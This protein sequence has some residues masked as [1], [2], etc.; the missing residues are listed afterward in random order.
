MPA[1]L[2]EIIRAAICDPGSVL[3]RHPD[4]RDGLWQT[5]AVLVALAGAGYVMVPGPV[6]T[7]WG[8]VPPTWD[9]INPGVV[10]DVVGSEARARRIVTYSADQVV[11][12]QATEW[13]PAPAPDGAA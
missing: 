5:R 9:G 10:A 12:R 3:P 1:G 6:R 13:R 8:T 7:E 2:T 4:D 11:S